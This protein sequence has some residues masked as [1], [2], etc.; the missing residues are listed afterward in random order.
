[1]S[2]AFLLGVFT[3]C[4][5]AYESMKPVKQRERAR[6]KFSKF[7]WGGLWHEPAFN[8][9]RQSKMAAMSR[10]T[11]RSVVF[12]FLHFY[13]LKKRFSYNPGHYNMSF[14]VLNSFLSLFSV[15]V[16]WNIF[17]CGLNHS[18]VSVLSFKR[19][20]DRRCLLQV[21][22]V[23]VAASVRCGLQQCSLLCHRMRV[24]GGDDACCWG[25][26]FYC[27]WTFFGLDRQNWQMWEQIY[28]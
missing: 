19:I 17:V 15:M 7:V 5:C 24:L 25:L 20:K 23:F 2:I 13:F 16:P 10:E 1:M 26:L 21:A 12:L 11:R 28:Y 6:Q 9:P 22:V 18:E 14:F 8:N 4:S 27:W 3:R